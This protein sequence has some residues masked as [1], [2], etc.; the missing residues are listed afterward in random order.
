MTPFSL[1]VDGAPMTAQMQR[2]GSQD[3]KMNYASG[4][5]SKPVYRLSL[6]DASISTAMGR[7][8][9]DDAIPRP[10]SDAKSEVPFTPSQ[11]P[12]PAHSVAQ[13]PEI[14]S[15]SKSPRKRAPAS[16]FLTRDSNTQVAMDL[17]DIDHP[18]S[19]S[20]FQEGIAG[21]TAEAQNLKDA[22]ATYRGSSRLT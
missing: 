21:A 4:W 12:R 15:P 13:Q 3:P 18:Q 11:I 8:S 1:D 22:I 9:L 7:L 17:E 19:L 10:A 20:V 16:S 6:R 2:N 14:P 5:G